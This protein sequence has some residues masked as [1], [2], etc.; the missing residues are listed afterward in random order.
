[1]NHDMGTA[2]RKLAAIMTGRSVAA[3]AERYGT[4]IIDMIPNPKST[5]LA[6]MNTS[7]EIQKRVDT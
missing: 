3:W 6:I 7:M 5:A 4:V 2:R 1:M